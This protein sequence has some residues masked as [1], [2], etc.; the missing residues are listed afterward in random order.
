MLTRGTRIS[1]AVIA[2]A[3]VLIAL[4]QIVNSVN[5]AMRV[6]TFATTRHTVER[7]AEIVAEPVVAETVIHL[8]GEAG[9]TKNFTLRPG[10]YEF[11]GASDESPI[12]ITSYNSAASS[13]WNSFMNVLTIVDPDEWPKARE[14]DGTFPGGPMRIEVRGDR[15][16]SID[17]LRRWCPNEIT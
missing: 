9:E 12:A 3:L 8:N 15:A 4:T 6:V 10:V 13:S 7:E 11:L 5:V 1:L 17:I 14:Y 16:W 2:G